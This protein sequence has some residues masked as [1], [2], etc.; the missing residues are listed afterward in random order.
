VAAALA[1]QIAVRHPAGARILPQAPTKSKF[2]RFGERFRAGFP[3]EEIEGLE[4]VC[5]GID[6]R[7]SDPRPKQGKM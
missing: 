6:L 3:H 7:T 2:F 5:G 1:P 4:G